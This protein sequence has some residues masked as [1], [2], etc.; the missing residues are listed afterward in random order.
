MNGLG[1]A[2]RLLVSTALLL[3]VA[4]PFVHAGDLDLRTAYS[5]ATD[6]LT[7][8][9]AWQIDRAEPNPHRQRWLLGRKVELKELMPRELKIR[10][11][12][13]FGV[14]SPGI[15]AVTTAYFRDVG[16]WF[17]PLREFPCEA[18][19]TS[20]FATADGS[21]I[22]AGLAAKSW[23]K[24]LER[25]RLLL[26]T[27]LKRLIAPTPGAA[28][29]KARLL[30]E[31][32]LARVDAAWRA[33]GK[34]DARKAEWK[35]YERAAREQGIC[36]GTQRKKAGSKEH[37][38]EYV[39]S[40]RHRPVPWEEMM[41][42][43][44]TGPSGRAGAGADEVRLLAR[45][46][47]KTWD[48]LFSVRLN[49]TIGARKLNGTFLIDSGSPTSIISPDFLNS[50]G[51]LPAWIAVPTAPLRRI[52][53]GGSPASSVGGLA[54]VVALDRVELGN[55]PL[56]LTEFALFDTEFF[57]QPDHPSSCCDGVLGSDFLRRYVVELQPGAPSEVKIWPAE[58][59][60]VGPDRLV[61]GNHPVTGEALPPS[62]PAE[63]SVQWFETALT[64]GGDPVSAC[65]SSR[66]GQSPTLVGVRWDTG[67][68]SAL[69]VHLPWQRAARAGRAA[70]WDVHC[71]P[72]TEIAIASDI[73]A[74][75]IQPD[76][77]PESAAIHTKVPAFSIG[78]ELLSRGRVYFDLP[79]GRIWF[80][81]RTSDE[82]LRR[83][84][85]GLVVKYEFIQGKGDARALVVKEIKKGSPAEALRERGLR[86]GM[87][88][89]QV[90][91]TDAELLDAWKIKRYFAGVYGEQVYI[92]W[93][94]P[95]GL[96]LGQM[97]VR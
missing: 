35:S 32:W 90:E 17:R 67:R 95:K 85:S 51:I 82:P 38:D 83:D 11:S 60:H 12:L 31:G 39:P 45:A 50:Q 18:E 20:W 72:A 81:D 24:L 71:G 42:P 58:N 53:W 37:Q 6:A 61:Y 5:V 54:P 40:T 9:K 91:K 28:L 8:E 70:G 41:E 87:V 46:P 48:G 13:L 55:L 30:F 68:E 33:A 3:L 14:T 73:P 43:P 36:E 62:E 57:S 4:S 59:F 25:Q 29:E 19:P 88:I 79:H 23:D 76:G 69:Y 78:M 16:P 80:P 66:Q 1:A 86:P 93:K 15:E 96:M 52:P 44:A 27:E 34:L 89:S 26:S 10:G 56:E 77:S 92:Q 75:F 21:R 74:T 65:I 84:H 7:T 63:N 97:K 22:A 94:T 47:A 2:A 64:P 49:L